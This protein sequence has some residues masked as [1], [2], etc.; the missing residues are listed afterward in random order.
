MLLKSTASLP[1]I[2]FKYDLYQSACVSGR[3]DY[4]LY[5]WKK[6]KNEKQYLKT[7]RIN[8]QGNSESYGWTGARLQ[9]CAT[10]R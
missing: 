6:R 2:F 9:N 4:S 1:V 5:I 8:I 10:I 3:M 7:I